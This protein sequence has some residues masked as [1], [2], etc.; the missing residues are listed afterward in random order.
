MSDLIEHDQEE[1]SFFVS[2]TDMVVGILFI[3]IILV[4]YFAFDFR[5]KEEELSNVE[6]SISEA[7]AEILDELERSLKQAGVNVSVDLDNGILRLPSELLFDPAS[8]ALKPEA[9][10]GVEALANALVIAS[11]CHVFLET[12]NIADECDPDT[13]IIDTIF[14]E[15]HT[16]GDPLLTRG[17]D[18]WNLSTERAV[19]TYR[20]LIDF[21][22]ILQ[23]LRNA[24][25]GGEPIFSVSGY[26]DTRPTSFEGFHDY[27]VLTKTSPVTEAQ[28]RKLI[29]S[30]SDPEERE[31]LGELLSRA[32][33]ANRR[34]DLRIIM[35]RPGIEAVQEELDQAVGGR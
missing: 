13:H 31:Q 7:R 35:A 21:Q 32:K 9:L 3:F 2:M 18:N 8:S 19:N 15:G 14:V 27:K 6:Q 24:D 5:D 29:D 11:R 33:K 17:R 16:D 34:I 4:M 25:I 22:P 23:E 1:E 28:L 10:F 30:T 12:D 26:A 20:K